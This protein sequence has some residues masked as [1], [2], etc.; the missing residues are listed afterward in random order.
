MLPQGDFKVKKTVLG[1]VVFF[2]LQFLYAEGWVAGGSFTF[3]HYSSND[4]ASFS[5]W[6]T[7]E[8]SFDE[9]SFGLRAGVS[10]DPR[11]SQTHADSYT[12]L[13]VSPYLRPTARIENVGVFVSAGIMYV[14]YHYAGWE[15]YHAF[16][17]DITP[18]VEYFLD[19]H[20]SLY[21]MFG[22]FQTGLMLDED[23]YAYHFINT[24]LAVGRVGFNIYF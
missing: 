1:F 3:D 16:C 10:Y 24:R 5:V 7:V 22:Y 4:E 11:P 2:A 21:V 6:P 15:D 19:D 17:V 13:F 14:Y 23:S 8:Y 12:T 9:V 20:V 18:G